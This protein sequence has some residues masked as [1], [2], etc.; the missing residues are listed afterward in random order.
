MY[1]KSSLS[2]STSTIGNLVVGYLLTNGFGYATV[3]G[4]VSVFHVAA[5]CLILVTVRRVRPLIVSHKEM[6]LTHA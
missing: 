4:L 3:F 5:F 2:T 1:Q 6:S